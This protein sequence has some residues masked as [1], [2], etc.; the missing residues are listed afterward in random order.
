LNYKK[1]I[2]IAG[3]AGF[4]GS[5]LCERLLKKNYKVICIDNLHTGN[6]NNIKNFISNKNFI[7]KKHDITNKLNIKAD[8]IL[9]FACPAS[10]VA[11]QTDPIKT[12]KTCVIGT[13]NLLDLS[14]KNKSI[15]LQASTSEIYGDPLTHP[16]K[17]NYW[18]NVNPIGIRS[19]YDEGKRCAETLCFDFKRFYKMDV[20]VVRIFNTYGPNMQVDDGRVISNFINQ[21]LRNKNITIY[22][23]GDQTRSFCFVDDL[24][25]VI[26]KIIEKKNKINQPI[27]IGNPEEQTIKQLANKII[28][29]TGTKSRI[30]YINLPPDDPY[31]RCPDITFAQKNFLWSPKIALKEG[32]LKTI[33]YFKNKHYY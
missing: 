4:I 19:C 16:Q 18:G 6:K 31:K 26:I 24:V 20:R 33:D 14:R 15:F 29:L 5:H 25:E 13:S 2:L 22:G 30:K 21:S 17:E 23:N 7:F 12:V 32:L 28:Q 10:P 8:Y 9:N 11:Y 27:N 3:G 1:K